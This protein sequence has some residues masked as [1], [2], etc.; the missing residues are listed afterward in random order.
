MHQISQMYLVQRPVSELHC[1][2]SLIVVL[3]FV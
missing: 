3:V 1:F 2:T